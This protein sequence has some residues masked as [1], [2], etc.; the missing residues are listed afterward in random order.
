MPQSNDDQGSAIDEQPPHHYVFAH[1]ALRQVCQANPFAFFGVMASPDRQEFLDGLW[2]KVRE[3]HAEDGEPCFSSTEIKVE[4]TL[5]GQY[6][7]VLVI[8]PPPKFWTEAY[9]VCAV[10]EVPVDEISERTDEKPTV[11]YFTLELGLNIET[12]EHYTM[13]CG[14]DDD[15]HVS[16]GV[17][18]DVTEKAFLEAV[19]R[20]IEKVH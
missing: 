19:A 8:M 2:D 6:P 9:M 3:R 13:F 20:M 11:K 7:A 14:W 16:Y 12:G 5:I 18:P 4:T 17:G 1:V 15:T 10:L